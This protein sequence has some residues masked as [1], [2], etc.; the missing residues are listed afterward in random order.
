[1]NQKDNI[2]SVRIS[3][4]KASESMKRSQ[5]VT[6]DSKEALIRELDIRTQENMKIRQER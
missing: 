4:G 2:A 3:K 1:M 6:A 5:K